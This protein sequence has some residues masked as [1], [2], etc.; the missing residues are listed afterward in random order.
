MPNP[1]QIPIKKYKGGDEGKELMFC[2][3]EE[4]EEG[5]NLFNFY[6][7]DGNPITTYVNGAP[8]SVAEHD[9]FNFAYLKKWWFVYRFH[10]SEGNLEAH[11]HWIVWSTKPEP[12]DG[13]VDPDETGTFQA[14]GGPHTDELKAK[15]SASS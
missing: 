15:A 2:Y 14:Q 4:V 3:F 1:N 8:S 5:S 7:P 6:D 11:G 9:D 10:I 13:D 12:G